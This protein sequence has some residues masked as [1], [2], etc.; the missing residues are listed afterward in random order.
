MEL[1]KIRGEIKRSK[2]TI[3]RDQRVMTIVTN[4]PY[5]Q[6]YRS[7]SWTKAWRLKIR[8]ENKPKSGHLTNDQKSPRT[9]RTLHCW[10]PQRGK[11]TYACRPALRSKPI[12]STRRATSPQWPI[13]TILLLHNIPT[14]ITQ[15]LGCRPSHTRH[16]PLSRRMRKT[17]LL[18]KAV[19][20]K[21]LFI[22][23][24]PKVF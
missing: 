5:E 22:H 7:T 12:F 1:D 2:Q 21:P 3:T 14:S 4:H 11:I 16:S 9:L 23:R 20:V 24:D 10:S 18:W 15:S 6:S 8:K 13:E 19:R 17:R